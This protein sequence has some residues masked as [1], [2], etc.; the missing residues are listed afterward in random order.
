MAWNHCLLG[1]M[2]YCAASSS[3]HQLSSPS[4]LVT[5]LDGE[6]FRAGIFLILCAVAFLKEAQT[7]M[8]SSMKL[9]VS[10]VFLQLSRPHQTQS[11][12]NWTES[13]RTDWSSL[14][15]NPAFM[16]W[17]CSISKKSERVQGILALM[18]L[19]CALSVGRWVHFPAQSKS[20]QKHLINLLFL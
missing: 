13:P 5:K 2:G 12:A 6:L 1:K 17:R 10:F 20:F 11:W 3:Y 14:Q 9:G 16:S 19:M 15:P 18:F 8:L 7:I 4:T